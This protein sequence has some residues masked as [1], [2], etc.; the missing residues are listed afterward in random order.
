MQVRRS[1]IFGSSYSVFNEDVELVEP[2]RK[3][4]RDT[5]G[6]NRVT[7]IFKAHFYNGVSQEVSE[8]AYREWKHRQKVRS[9]F[10]L[11][12][13]HSLSTSI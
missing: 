4:Y 13:L 5:N 6:K 7:F 2:V 10:I 1:L 12:K 11:D 8:K 3:I 9:I